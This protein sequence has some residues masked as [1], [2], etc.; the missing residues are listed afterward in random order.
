MNKTGASGAII[1]FRKNGTT[2]GGLGVVGGDEM[3]IASAG[4]TAGSGLRFQN[5]GHLIYPTD[6]LGDVSNGDLDLGNTSYRF[7]DI[8]LYR[9]AHVGSNVGSGQVSIYTNDISTGE[10]NGLKLVNTNASAGTT[11]H[12]TPGLVGQNN[13]T[14][15]IRNG[16]TNVNALE[17]Q[18][19]GVATFGNTIIAT[20]V[21]QHQIAT[22]L[23]SE[24]IIKSSKTSES[25]G[26]IRMA[27]SAASNPTY[28][29]VDDTNTGMFT[30]GADTLN[31]TTAGSERLRIDSA[32]RVKI[33]TT[34][35]AHDGKF[36]IAG[37][38][39]NGIQVFM[40]HNEIY[41]VGTL[42]GSAGVSTKVATLSFETNHLRACT[43]EMET[44][45]H[46]YN[47]GGD[48]WHTRHF[49]TCMSEGSNTRLNTRISNH[50]F[51][52]GTTNRMTTAL[53]KVS[54]SNLWQAV[55][56]ISGEY[57]G[58]FHFRMQGFGVANCPTSLSIT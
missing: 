17:I 34:S 28:A 54:G 32:G 29:F 22:T 40:Q 15:T 1:E 46:K 56:T 36:N 41:V 9:E 51:S 42:I 58:N 5:E 47:N 14:L 13:N 23:F 57:Q 18:T 30:S 2:I 4:T 20:N 53:N 8:Y 37:T 12:I 31:F 19:S 38:G 21:G 49:Y 11:W 44:S 52:E 45:G 10:N 50:E 16:V 7:K 27:V 24:N 55:I 35:T 48:Y 25:G 26:F 6:G 43:I 39:D 33:G 3:Y